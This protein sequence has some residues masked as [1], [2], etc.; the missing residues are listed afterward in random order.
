[1]RTSHSRAAAVA[2]I[3]ILSLA[4]GAALAATGAQFVQVRRGLFGE[5]SDA[6]RFAADLWRDPAA[7]G[8][9]AQSATI[10]RRDAMNMSKLFPQGSSASDG[11]RTAALDS[12]WSERAGFER[13]ANQLADEAGGLAAITRATPSSEV[14][15]QLVAIVATCKACHRDYRAP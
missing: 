7:Y 3:L 4:A 9:V 5:M 6:L 13:L 8:D 15:Q 14:R 10:I 12:V 11:L 2:G 1:M